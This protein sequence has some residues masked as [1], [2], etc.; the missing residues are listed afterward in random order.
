MSETRDGRSP[1]PGERLN[2]S[3]G[4]L[5]HGVKV[6]SKMSRGLYMKGFVE[7]HVVNCLVDTG[8]VKTILSGEVYDRLQQHKRFLLRSENTVRYFPRG[9]QYQ[10]DLWYWRDNANTRKAGIAG[11]FFGS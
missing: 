7:Q 11:Q 2:D 3:K 9:W 6:S 10:Q 4:H 8:S 1:Q 5:C